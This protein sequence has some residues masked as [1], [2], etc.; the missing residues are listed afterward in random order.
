MRR[1]WLLTSTKAVTA[2]Q[3]LNQTLCQYVDK[4]LLSTFKKT[5]AGNT[6]TYTRQLVCMSFGKTV[7]Q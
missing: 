7:G 4:C 2:L 1:L 6:Y 3:D 5:E